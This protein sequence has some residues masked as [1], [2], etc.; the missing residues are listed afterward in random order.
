MSSCQLRPPTHQLSP[1]WLTGR[2]LLLVRGK[3]WSY[4]AVCSAHASTA[5]RCIIVER[6]SAHSGRM[7]VFIETLKFSWF[8]QFLTKQARHSAKKEKMAYRNI[9][10]TKSLSSSFY[11]AV[12][13]HFNTERTQ[14]SQC[15]K[16]K[17]ARNAKQECNTVRLVNNPVLAIMGKD[18]WL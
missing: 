11:S 3:S 7:L 13:E 14:T 2:P 4:V 6:R 9:W 5:A 18:T 15:K 17:I 12:A 1:G 8:A 10:C 16:W